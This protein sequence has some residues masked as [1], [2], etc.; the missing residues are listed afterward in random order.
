MA[1]NRIQRDGIE[2]G[3]IDTSKILD[4]IL[5][6]ADITNDTLTN[7]K[8]SNSAA[9]PTSKLSGLATSATTDTTNAANITSGSLATARVN[10]GTVAG[11]I[12]QVDG[13]GNLPAIDGSLLTGI[14][15][16]TK[17]ASDPTISTNPSAGVGAEWVNTTSGE[18]YICTDATAGANVWTN[19][20]AGSGDVLPNVGVLHGSSYGYTIGGSLAGPSWSK[21]NIID[22][23]AFASSANSVDVGDLIAVTYQA[24]SSS[25]SLYGYCAGGGDGNTSVNVIQKFSTTVNANATD[26]GDLETGTKEPIGHTSSTAG[27]TVGGR[28]YSIP[29]SATLN[30]IQKYAF[31]SDGNATDVANL[32]V[33]RNAPISADSTTHGFTFGGYTA[34]PAASSTQNS[35]DRFQ[36][37]NDSDATDWADL[38]AHKVR[39]AG[40]QSTTH[41]Y[42]AAGYTASPS[43]ATYINVIEKFTFASQNNSTNV[44]DTLSAEDEGVAGHS[45]TSYGYLSGAYQSPVTALDRIQRWSFSSDGNSTDVGNLTAGRYGTTGTQV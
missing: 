4:G 42:S 30:K 14:V 28:T 2:D 10:V 44:G 37:S 13:S 20:G 32:N 24:S 33:N 19:V 15:S 5:G 23:F 7:A 8:F 45:T 40:T 35:I 34:H 26:V 16:F 43:P 6:T 25:A 39:A 9:I 22:K 3:A 36:F 41:G 17:S 12:L 31:A 38:L 18:V 29:P 21:Q 27:Y 1:L 11:K